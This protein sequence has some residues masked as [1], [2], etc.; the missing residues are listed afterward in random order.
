MTFKAYSD[1]S[2]KVTINTIWAKTTILSD[3]MNLVASAVH[4]E[5]SLCCIADRIW[6]PTNIQ[7]PVSLKFQSAGLMIIETQRNIATSFNAMFK[8][9][10][11]SNEYSPKKAA[12][13][14][15]TIFED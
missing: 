14:L 7:C 9:Y 10:L 5:L 11:R 1:N 6:I 4:D 12:F 8:D 13:D 3:D 15:C 2:I